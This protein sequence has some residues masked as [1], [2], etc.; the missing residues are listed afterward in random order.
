MRLASLCSAHNTLIKHKNSTHQGT[1]N[2]ILEFEVVCDVTFKPFHMELEG[3][4]CY[5]SY[6]WISCWHSRD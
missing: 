3:G 5:R 2:A 6:D 1:L 4:V